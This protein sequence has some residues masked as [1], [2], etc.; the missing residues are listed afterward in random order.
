MNIQSNYYSFVVTMS[1]TIFH[2]GQAKGWSS[3]KSLYKECLFDH[4]NIRAL[5]V[6]R[7]KLFFVQS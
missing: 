4:L 6:T 2:Q 1:E 3:R 5:L 7:L